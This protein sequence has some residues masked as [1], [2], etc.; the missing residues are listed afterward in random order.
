MWSPTDSICTRSPLLPRTQLPLH[1]SSS[2][3][4]G[5][6]PLRTFH[7]HTLSLVVTQHPSAMESQRPAPD[8]GAKKKRRRIHLNCEECRRTKSKCEFE[9]RKR[10]A[11]AVASSCEQA[12]SSALAAA[13]SMHAMVLSGSTDRKVT[14]H[15]RAASVSRKVRAP[16]R[17][18]G[19]E[20]GP[21]TQVWRTS[22]QTRC[23]RC[24]SRKA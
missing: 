16:W 11:P 13:S 21:N 14:D 17:A 3:S 24:H 8:L 2:R 23:P 4:P 22:A 10:Q 19:N 7:N 12:C 20:Q 15:G 6:S 1:T 18:A 9:P 5:C